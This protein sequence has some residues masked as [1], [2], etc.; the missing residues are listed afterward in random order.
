MTDDLIK[1]RDRSLADY[2]FEP[3]IAETGKVVSVGDGIAWISGL[4]SAAIDDVLILADGSEAIVFDLNA[5]GVGAILLKQTDEL[6]SGVTTPCSVEWVMLD[7]DRDRGGRRG[8]PPA[9]GRAAAPRS[10]GPR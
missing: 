6:T 3:R 7:S 4:P 5:S 9:R 10:R 1:S 2:R 8:C